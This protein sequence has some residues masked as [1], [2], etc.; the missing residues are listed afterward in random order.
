MGEEHSQNSRVRQRPVVHQSL[1]LLKVLRSLELLKVPQSPELLKV[2]QSLEL[3]KELQSLELLK[4]LQSL[5][6]RHWCYQS[7]TQVQGHWGCQ[8]QAH[9]EQC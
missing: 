9:S 4:V 2:P 5:A 1:V 3:L 7:P 8:R 6:R